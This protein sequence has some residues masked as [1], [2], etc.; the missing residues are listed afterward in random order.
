MSADRPVTAAIRTVEATRALIRE[1]ERRGSSPSRQGVDWPA[2]REAVD[3]DLAALPSLSAEHRRALR[4]LTDAAD[5]RSDA[6]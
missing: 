5:D 4:A 2:L 1:I 6:L 3:S